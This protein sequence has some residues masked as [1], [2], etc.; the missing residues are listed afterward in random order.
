MI[1]SALPPLGVD[2]CNSFG[3][4]TPDVLRE[5]GATLLVF[6]SP[7]CEPCQH[8][9]EPLNWLVAEAASTVHPVVVYRA[10]EQ[11]CRA[12]L[13]VFPLH[14]PVVCDAE[15][16]IT[17]GLGVHRTPLGLLY[18]EQ[19]TLIRKGGLR[20]TRICWRCWEMARLLLRL[21]PTSFHGL[22]RLTRSVIME[23]AGAP[24]LHGS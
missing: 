4:V 24:M 18:D 10:D 7:M 6:L 5:Q 17:M 14:M 19:G 2:T 21:R 16:S 23:C 13:S 1:G 22:Y 20:G 12:F 8:A 3:K 11:A 15:A 9:V